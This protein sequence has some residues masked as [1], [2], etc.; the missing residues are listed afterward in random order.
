MPHP[1]T[2]PCG[3]Y[4]AARRH[5]RRHE[6]LCTPCEQARRDWWRERARIGYSIPAFRARENARTA[7][8]LA[9]RRATDPDWRARVN[10]QR[11]QRRRAELA[12]SALLIDPVVVERLCR[13]ETTPAT[14]NEREAAARQM[15]ADGHT[16]SV[17]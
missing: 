8:R 7:A 14:P 4:A 15:A 13:G 16:R 9:R 10:A 11:A 17:I 6:P 5:E 2:K 1:I 3:T 12:A